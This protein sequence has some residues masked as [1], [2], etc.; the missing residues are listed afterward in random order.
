MMLIALSLIISSAGAISTFFGT[1][2][3]NF[4][5]KEVTH[6]EYESYPT[7]ALDRMIDLC[8]NVR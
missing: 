4:E 5:G 1:T 7:M 3:D 8:T 6:L 2:R